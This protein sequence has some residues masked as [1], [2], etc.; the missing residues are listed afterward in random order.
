MS[1]E[2]VRKLTV[3]DIGSRILSESEVDYFLRA[4][5]VHWV[6]SGGKDEPHALLTSGRHSGEYYDCTFVL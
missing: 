4:Y 5:F 2:E 1:F 6:Y 3:D